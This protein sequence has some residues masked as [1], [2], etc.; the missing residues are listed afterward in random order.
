LIK[1]ALDNGRGDKLL[2]EYTYLMRLTEGKIDKQGQMKETSET[3]EAYVP[4]LRNRDRTSAVLLKLTEKGVPLPADKLEKERQ[5]AAERLLKS[6]AEAQK[7]NSRNAAEFSTKQVI[8]AYFQVRLSADVDL[9]IKVLLRACEFSAPRRE[10]LAGRETI[11]LDFRPPAADVFEKNLRYLAR[12][13]GT[14]WID[15]QE[16]I[17]VRAEGWPGT[18][19]AR[20]GK[21]A[22]LYEQ[23]RLPDG[24]WLTRLAQLNGATHH[25]VFGSLDKDFTFE[26]SDYKRFGAEVKDVKL[27]KPET[28]N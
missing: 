19:T 23:I 13:K 12:T 28:K 20:A 27:G 16:R 4:T 10:M 5:K 25:A 15:A 9:N 3:F 24:Y 14:V 21:P 26:F 11:A 1:D 6:E 22:F 18:T 8:G 7:H 2:T 17:L